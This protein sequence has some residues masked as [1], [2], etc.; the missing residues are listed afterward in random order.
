MKSFQGFSSVLVDTSQQLNLVKK[1]TN[2]QN[3]QTFSE[4]W[5]WGGKEKDSASFSWPCLLHTFAWKKTLLI[6]FI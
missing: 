5:C 4:H 3:R 1:Q 6:D 2:K